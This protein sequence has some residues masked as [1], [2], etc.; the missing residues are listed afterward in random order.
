MT[1]LRLVSEEGLSDLPRDRIL[2]LQ[3]PAP[4]PTIG[5]RLSGHRTPRHGPLLHSLLPRTPPAPGHRVGSYQGLSSG[6]RVVVRVACTRRRGVV[7]VAHPAA[8]RIAFADPPLGA[9]DTVPVAARAAVVAPHAGVVEAGVGHVL[10]RRAAHA[11]VL[12]GQRHAVLAAPSYHHIGGQLGRRSVGFAV[13]AEAE[14]HAVHGL[15]AGFR[16]WGEG[17]CARRKWRGLK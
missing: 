4:S 1:H 9:V 3:S 13:V 16:V 11:R 7:R 8:H 6:R 14:G 2:G 15:L 17:G 12:A 10:D 5:P